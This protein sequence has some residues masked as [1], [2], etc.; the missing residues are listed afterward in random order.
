MPASLALAHLGAR[1]R[2]AAPR[3]GGRGALRAGTRAPRVARRRVAASATLGPSPVLAALPPAVFELAGNANQLVDGCGVTGTC[4]Q[5]DAPPFALIGGAVVV[6]AALLFSVTFGLKS[7][8]DAQAEMA[9]RDK[10]FFGK[11]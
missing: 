10:D 6:S 2:V 1:V 8:A 4:G 9:E 3:A 7:G 5:V 11:K